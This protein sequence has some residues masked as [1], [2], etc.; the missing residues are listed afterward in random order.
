VKIRVLTYNI[1]K[2]IGGLDRRYAPE[3]VRDTIAHYD[4]DVV[5]LQEVDDKVKRSSHH[6]Q[7]D[8]LGEML[9][10]R[11][12]TWFANVK[13]RSGGEYGNA[14]LSKFPIHETRNIDLT[15]PP[16]KRRSVLHALCRV[17]LHAAAK[18]GHAAPPHPGKPHD[19]A[20]DQTRTLHFFNMHLGLAQSERKLQ[21][22]QFLES[23]PFAGLAH[24]T[25]VIVAG[26]FNDVWGT[27]GRLLHP[28]GFAGVA[29]PLR[30]FPAYAPMRALD[31]IYVR[32]SAKLT[33]VQRGHLALARQ[34]SDHLP[35][36][37]DITL[38]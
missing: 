20:H 22:R 14:I 17:P 28:S 9:G 27:L 18:D 15:I 13:V 21:L 19:H 5:M 25:P 38:E 30:T 34:A 2:C 6:C 33:H 24:N 3:R 11:H 29:R 31:S 8:V 7:V 36:I 23:H 26:D 37:A 35:L 32:G 10:L 1:H 4:P 16:R 12:R